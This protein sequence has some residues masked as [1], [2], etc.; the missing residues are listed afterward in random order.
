METT[1]SGVFADEAQAGKVVERLVAAGFRRDE[2][3]LVTSE[4]PNRHE[5]I[6]EETSDAP[7]GLVVG[8]GVGGVGAAIAAFGVCSAFPEFGVPGWLAGLGGGVV[9]GL[10]GAL[11]GWLIGSGTGHMVQEE[12]EHLLDAGMVLVAIN[13]ERTRAAQA[14]KVLA[15]SGGTAMSTSVHRKHQAVVQQSA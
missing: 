2:V 11:V 6:G 4:M 7:R 14:E 3:T 1:V 15:E 13:T 10:G 8:L 12:Y 5:L 9:G